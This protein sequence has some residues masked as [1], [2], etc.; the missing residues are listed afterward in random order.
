MHLEC[1]RNN[2]NHVRELLRLYCSE[3]TK[4]PYIT[5]YPIIF[6]S[7]KMHNFNKHSKS[8]TQVV[9]KQQDK[10]KLNSVQVGVYIVLIWSIRSI[11]YHYVL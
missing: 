4:P 9:A 7:D 2:H 8:G 3:N 5:G 6:I 1:A 10:I 11:G